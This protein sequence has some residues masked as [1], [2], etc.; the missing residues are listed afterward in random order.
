[1]SDSICLRLSTEAH[2]YI[3]GSIARPEGSRHIVAT[4]FV[5]ILS[6]GVEGH[7][8]SSI[9]RRLQRFVVKPCSIRQ[10]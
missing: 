1:M 7:G 5:E 10:I 9:G 6:A 4:D 3:A 2:D 8:V